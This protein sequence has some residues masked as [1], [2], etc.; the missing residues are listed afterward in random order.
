MDADTFRKFC[1][2]LPGTYDAMPFADGRN[3]SSRHF[4]CFYVSGKWFALADFQT[5]EFCNLK[6]PPAD[7]EYLT[8][9]YAGIKPGWH[10]NKRHWI[11]VYFHMDVRDEMVFELV[12]K[13]Y[14]TV[15]A[16][17]P[18]KERDRLKE[19]PSYPI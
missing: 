10:M 16:K 9:T 17:L 6:S 13:A 8:Q 1:L 2:S 4:V 3:E 18:K 5:F 14:D 7:T 15:V 11:S 19:A 12:R